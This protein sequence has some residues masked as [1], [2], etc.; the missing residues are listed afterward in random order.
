MNVYARAAAL[1][2][3]VLGSAIPSISHAEEWRWCA[4]ADVST[5][6]PGPPVF[7][8]TA[9]FAS[10]DM[11]DY[12]AQ[13]ENHVRG[14]LAP[15]RGEL[16]VSCSPAFPDE[17]AAWSHQMDWMASLDG[18]ARLEATEWPPEKSR[19]DKPA[20]AIA[21]STAA[22]PAASSGSPAPLP[23]QAAS[24]ATPA[25]TGKQDDAAESARVES[26][27][28]SSERRLFA[29]HQGTRPLRFSFWVGME[30]R[31]GDAHNPACV[32][33]IVERPGPKDW[34]IM[35]FRPHASYEQAQKVMDAVQPVF[36]D[37][38]RAA[39]GRAVSGTVR[40]NWN[41]EEGDEESLNRAA[42][43]DADW[44]VQID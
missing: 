13:F 44:K 41:A 33:N 27:R 15:I 1:G 29:N 37:K 11:P 26:T 34:E 17:D 16:T 22:K 8:R 21:T 31:V 4:A 20:D 5:D 7:R 30:P 38:C 40:S 12:Q 6:D 35:G 3:L 43:Q 42:N 36:L 25:H 28:Q 24:A 14:E 10:D 2:L 19:A 39:S 32:S 18:A 9:P 23:A